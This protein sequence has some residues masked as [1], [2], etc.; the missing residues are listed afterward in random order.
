MAGVA[1]AVAMLLVAESGTGAQETPD[2]STCVGKCKC[3]WVSGRKTAEC[4]AANL[5][6]IPDNLSPD[7]QHVDLSGNKLL[8]LPAD[9]FKAVGLVHLHKVNIANICSS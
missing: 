3:K 5:T 4:S 2:W 8:S 9:A 7:I 6:R 1:A